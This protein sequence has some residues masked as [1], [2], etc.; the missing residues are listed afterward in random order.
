M[1]DADAQL[2]KGSARSFAEASFSRYDR[3]I[4]A[5]NLQSIFELL[6]TFWSLSVAIKMASHMAIAYCTA[7]LAISPLA[8][9]SIRSTWPPRLDNPPG[10]PVHWWRYLQ[11]FR[12]GK[13]SSLL[14]LLQ[15]DFRIVLGCCDDDDETTPDMTTPI[16]LVAK[17]RVWASLDWCPSTRLMHAV[18][19]LGIPRRV[20][21]KFNSIVSCLPRPKIFASNERTDC[22]LASD[23]HWLNILKETTC[24]ENHRLA[25]YGFSKMKETACK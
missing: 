9:T 23:A 5:M 15:N 24:N 2:G 13:G 17:T 1:L 3:F 16:L 10:W 22:S 12:R 6:R 19:L 20:F 25:D 7:V 18:V 11:N 14:E 8:P 21:L 4:C